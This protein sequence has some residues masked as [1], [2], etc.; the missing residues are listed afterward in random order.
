LNVTLE[1]RFGSAIRAKSVCGDLDRGH[2]RL[3]LR[4]NHS[5]ESLGSGMEVD[6]GA[7]T[8]PEAIKPCP[9]DIAHP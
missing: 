3:D 5:R 1:K 8:T 4:G 9:S 6:D 2:R 7:T